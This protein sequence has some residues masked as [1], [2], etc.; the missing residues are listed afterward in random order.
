M[1]A[2]NIFTN[3][4]D[5]LHLKLFY[6][7]LHSYSLFSYMSIINLNVKNRLNDMICHLTEVQIIHC[8]YNIDDEDIYS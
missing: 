2:K 8:Q 1:N 3:C 6:S 4:T 5:A 7:Y